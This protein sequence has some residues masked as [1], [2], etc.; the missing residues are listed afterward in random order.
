MT[1]IEESVI[2]NWPCDEV[3][4]YLETRSND[5]SW[6]ETVLESQ[7]LD[8]DG[9]DSAG[10]TALGRRGRMVMKI[11]GRRAEF[12]DEV[13]EYQPGRRIAHRT[14]EGPFPLNT[15]CACEPTAGGCRATLTGEADR[16]IGGWFGPLVEPFVIRA[17]RRSFKADLARLKK[18]L[19]ADAQANR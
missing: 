18:I 5:P 17:I 19:E 13:S 4:S 7:W 6:M 10:P 16:L 8:A 9:S 11:Q 14:V 2:I 3:F 1:R 12:I 15:A